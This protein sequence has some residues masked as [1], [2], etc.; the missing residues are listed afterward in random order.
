MRRRYCFVIFT[1]LFFSL[2]ACSTNVILFV[3]D[4]MGPH[5][6]SVANYV[7]YK[8]T[9]ENLC[10]YSLPTFSLVDTNNASGGVTDSAAAGT[11]L[12]TGKRTT[13]SVLGLNPSGVPIKNVA[14]IAKE[15]QKAVGIITDV[16]I[17]DATPAAFVAHTNNRQ[18]TKEI[19]LA[20]LDLQPDV[21]MGMGLSSF[22]KYGREQ[23]KW[24]S[25]DLI[26]E[27]S[28]L[29]YSINYNLSD[30]K[31]TSNAKI[32]GLFQ[33][34]EY[35]FGRDS[36]YRTQPTLKD[37]TKKALEVLS[38]NENGF[39]LI[40]EA[41]WI[42]GS[43]HYNDIVGA[44]YDIFALNEAVKEALDFIQKDPDTLII[45]TADH[46]TGGMSAVPSTLP[47][48]VDRLPSITRITYQIDSLLGNN[49]SHEFI[50]TVLLDSG[51][52]KFS[53]DDVKSIATAAPG[54]E[55]C[56]KIGPV[57]TKYV[58]GAKFTTTGHSAQNVPLFAVGKRSDEI[59][60][61]LR[62]DELGQFI[63]NVIQGK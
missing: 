32:V 58:G 22:T 41:G 62:N 50:K 30:L 16:A 49:P 6:V 17:T 45:V 12:A 48:L 33:N 14:E 28:D 54:W 34:I 3:G 39:F 59:P 7:Y 63:A 29:G 13:N 40:V 37:M 24:D 56:T 1:L 38:Q 35:A 52:P 43:G 19:S 9:G 27:F 53:L 42:D 60:K 46:E 15:L 21:F 51:I 25:R 57:I 31:K 4:G 44:I 8:N 47:D 18:N 5:Q 36:L 26:N 55:R 2:I 10:F 61:T 23:N 11:A 20:F